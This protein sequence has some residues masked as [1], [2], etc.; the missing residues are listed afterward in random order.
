MKELVTR[1]SGP[2]KKIN[3]HDE[4]EL[5][6]LRHKYIRRVTWNPTEA[7]MAPYYSIIRHIS[8]N[9]YY[10]Y[11]NLLHMVGFEFEDIINI[12]KVHLVSYL[13]LFSVQHV[14]EK[15]DAF[16]DIFHEQH[17]AYPDKADFLNKEK[18]NFTMFLKQ[19]YE[20][21]IRIS[22][23]KARNIKGSLTDEYVVY[24]GKD[25]P[26]EEHFRLRDDNAKY[27]YKKLDISVFKTLKKLMVGQTGPVYHHNGIYYVTVAVD[28]RTLCLTD[29]IMAGLDPRESAHNLNPEEF[30]LEAYAEK[31]FE[32]KKNA[33]YSRSRTYRRMKIKKFIALHKDDPTYTIEVR[34]ARKML[35]TKGL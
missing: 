25:A 34:A 27:G 9:T 13:G 14:P 35:K 31:D 16:V 8:K 5:C 20:D 18:S 24:F 32:N 10:T 19:R 12:G 28:H 23:L 17:R 22:Y 4:F 7:D 2:E 30:M 33:F 29:F 3:C 11:A 15:H 6:Y 1:P 21:V 26:P